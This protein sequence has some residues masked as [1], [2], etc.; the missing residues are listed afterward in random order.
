MVSLRQAW[1]PALVS[2]LLAAALFSITLAG[3]Y[4]YDDV[5]I[6]AGDARVA[7]PD[8]W[9][10][11]WTQGYFPDGVD[12]L[13]RP[14]TSM[15]Y[16]LQWW[17]NGDRPWA[18]HL[19][20]LLLYAAC[21]AVVAL[22]AFRLGGTAVA[23]IA[24]LLFAV[25]PIHVEVVAELV[26]R[27]DLI[28]T[29]AFVGAIL[30]YLR[31][32]LT[33]GRV[34][35]IFGC[36]VV[37]LLSKEQG[38][39][40]PLVLLILAAC[41]RLESPQH[42]AP[43]AAGRRAHLWLA[44]LLCWGWAGYI[45]FREWM[46]PMEW[47]RHLLDWTI[48]PMVRAKGW[49]IW[50]VPVEMLGRYVQLLVVPWKLSIDYGGQVIGW[51][52][53]PGDPY[54]YVGLAAI[55][56]WVVLLGIALWRRWGGVVF[57]LLMLALTWGMVSNL[58]VYIGTN[59]GERLMFLPS[60]FFLILVAM[61]LARL[62]RKVWIPLLVGLLALGAIRSFTYARHWNDRLGF[63]EYSLRNQPKSIRL[64]LLV[65]TE[66]KAQGQLDAAAR[67]FDEAIRLQPD[68]W[69]GWIGA[70]EVALKQHRL[71]DAR[72]YMEQAWKLVPNPTYLWGRRDALEKLEA[73][74]KAASRPAAGP[75]PGA[76][77]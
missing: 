35:G 68:Y 65:G 63:Y 41:R 26:G 49:A 60:A 34:W 64:T 13:Y 33:M 57:C 75:A 44:L 55:G 70:F 43:D 62:P 67:V 30:L 40:L 42:P 12:N 18:F 32:P 54:L 17:L 50:L 11:F 66:L 38:L 77:H 47:D 16:G 51:T 56:V 25:H 10:R 69:A 74:Q 23:W 27:A 3:T 15:S 20:S 31:R 14:L 7:H 36:C 1:R 28:C 29:L 45:A 8:Q 22:L 21:A 72:R 5:F 52:I 61:G 73:Q 37:A 39:L 48:N 24:G 2:A 6:V 71:A 53:H 59:F 9:G 46:L 4:I 76:R 58:G 19:V